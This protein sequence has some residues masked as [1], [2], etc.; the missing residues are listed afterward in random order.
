MSL[1]ISEIIAHILKEFEGVAA[2]ETWGETSF[3][4]NPSKLLPRGTYFCTLKQKDGENDKG[5]NLNRQKV[6]RFNFGLPT[7]SFV[8]TFGE[9]PK[10]PAKG[11][12]IEGP[13]DFTALNTLMPHPIY[14]WMGWV[15]ILN[16][17]EQLFSEIQPLLRLAYEKAKNGFEKRI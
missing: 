17:S 12:I 11:Q 8:K 7:K 2:V 13:W 4:Y 10:R 14:G 9:K 15:A 16:P 3:F 6:Y 5:S 1:N